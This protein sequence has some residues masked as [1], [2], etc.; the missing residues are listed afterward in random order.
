MRSKD[1][2]TFTRAQINFLTGIC[3]QD[4]VSSNLVQI[5]IASKYARYMQEAVNCTASLIHLIISD[6]LCVSQFCDMVFVAVD[7]PS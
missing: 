2:C 3:T 7:H 6:M 4:T 5:H 1:I